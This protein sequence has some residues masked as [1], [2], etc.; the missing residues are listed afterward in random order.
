VTWTELDV[1]CQ[2][3]TKK[4]AA[5]F[6]R[7]GYHHGN[8]KEALI[9]AARALIAE[10]GPAGFTLAEAA[11]VAGVSAAAPYRH[12]TD[13]EALIAEV[14]Q[15]G[16]AEFG[17]RL[18]GAWSGV[19]ADPV[20]GFCR[21]GSTYLAFARDEPGYYGAMFARGDAQKA[22]LSRKAGSPAFAALEQAIAR[23]GAH[24]T[25]SGDSIDV[26]ALAYQV[27]ALSHGIAML[28]AG[29]MMPIGDNGASAE[30]LLT[31]GVEALIA[32]SARKNRSASSVKQAPDAATAKGPARLK[33]ARRRRPPIA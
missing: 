31:S 10:R 32:G 21:M 29:G 6:H 8:L 2:N 27:W 25:H 33:Q 14:A 16:F 9:A 20:I 1:K 15:R 17:A 7:K 26:R 3:M 18:G 30:A 23:V 19:V 5:T 28:S 13:R 24:M 4:K 11:R 12:F 22:P